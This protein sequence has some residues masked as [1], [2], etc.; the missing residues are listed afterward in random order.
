MTEKTD[1]QPTW[2]W[3]NITEYDPIRDLDIISAHMRLITGIGNS[4]E[5]IPQWCIEVEI[6]DAWDYQQSIM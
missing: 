6:A 1:K 2:N 3:P 4:W 5:G